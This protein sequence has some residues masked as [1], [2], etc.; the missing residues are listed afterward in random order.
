MKFI[1]TL[2]F[3]LTAILA[4]GQEK[5]FSVYFENDKYEPDARGIQ[6]ILDIATFIQQ[7]DIVIHE[8]QM[9]GYTDAPASELYN[10]QLS[11]NRVEAVNNQ[12]QLNLDTKTELNINLFW[13]GEVVQAALSQLHYGQRCVDVLITYEQP[14]KVVVQPESDIR[15]LWSQLK[16][17]NQIFKIDPLHD[18]LLQGDQG[19]IIQIPAGAFK[20]PADKKD[21]EVT[22]VL[23]EF[24]DYSSM[25]INNMTTMAD[26]MQLE[27]GG[28]IFLNAYVGNR[29]ITVFEDKPLT[30]MF[31]G[32]TLVGG[33]QFFAGNINQQGNMNWNLTETDLETLTPEDYYRLIN[34]SQFTKKRYRK[35]CPYFFCGIREDLGANTKKYYEKRAY[36]ATDWKAYRKYTDSLCLAYGVRNFSVLKRM[37][38]NKVTQV[39]DPFFYIAKTSRLGYMNCDKFYKLPPEKLTLL[40]VDIPPSK[41]TNTFLVY[42]KFRSLMMPNTNSVTQTEFNN[43]SKQAKCKAVAIKY[44]NN[45]AYLSIKEIKPG[46]VDKVIPEFVALTPDQLKTELKK[47]R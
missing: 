37:L 32:D 9:H 44:E 34:P 12:L 10:I 36:D 46:Q 30:I 13:H 47:L 23:E 1:A 21:A 26:G 2:L 24:Y 3:S 4:H 27:T 43:I 35:N 33:M 19:T 5:Y 31:P 7:P 17:P 22:I 8:V 29:E 11:K 41:N 25:I 16:D 18:T 20:I 39:Q 45:I 28:M 6:V 38:Y 42:T 15:Q 40:A 14:K